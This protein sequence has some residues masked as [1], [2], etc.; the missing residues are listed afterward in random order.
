MERHRS[1]LAPAVVAVAL[2]THALC[3]PAHAENTSIPPASQPL[4]GP[5]ATLERLAQGYRAISPEQVVATFTADYRFHALGDSLSTFIGGNS[6]E[7]EARAVENMLR[8][9]GRM[10]KADSV[11]MRLNGI[12]ENT[13]PEH[14]DSSQFYRVLT[15]SQFDMG[16][17]MI[18]GQ[19]MIVSREQIFHLVRG[20]VAVLVDG[21]VGDA[22]LWYIRRWIEDVTGIREMLS[23]QQGRCG[24]P[25]PPRAGPRSLGGNIT[26][27]AIRP[28]INPACA[29]LEVTCALPGSEPARVEV[30]D[31]SGRLVNRRQVPVTGTGE[32]TVEAG[33]GARIIPG[34]YW[35]RL[36]QAA[37]KP[38]TQMVVV[39]R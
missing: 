14:P 28:L 4:E 35:V 18:D 13:D 16:V 7:D 3:A 30:Y 37:R 11:G 9:N 24:D 5:Q 39:A 17:R 26:A 23:G 34:V 36:S 19:R 38:S 25:E 21:Q 8:G 1:L 2:V 33:R 29:K 32:I 22:S 12:R 31:V 27:L 15:V 10:Q 20:D 6:R